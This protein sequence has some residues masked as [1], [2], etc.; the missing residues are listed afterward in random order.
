MSAGGRGL[1]VYT[2]FYDSAGN[3]VRV[4]QSSSAVEPKVWIFCSPSPDFIESPHLTVDDAKMVRAA[5]DRFIA[6]ATS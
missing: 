6:Q 4:Q 3:Q 1:R 5:L 2:E